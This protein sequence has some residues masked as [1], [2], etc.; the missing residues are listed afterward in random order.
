L[1]IN[2]TNVDEFNEI[3]AS[4]TDLS[5]VHGIDGHLESF[6]YGQCAAGQAECVW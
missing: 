1:K 4:K 3:L 2:H 5:L 6:V